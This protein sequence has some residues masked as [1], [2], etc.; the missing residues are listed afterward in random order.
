MGEL[1]KG[2]RLRYGGDVPASSTL[3]PNLSALYSVAHA[4]VPTQIKK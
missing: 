4:R 1:L 3:P 2:S